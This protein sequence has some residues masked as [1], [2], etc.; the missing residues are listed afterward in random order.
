MEK[1]PGL[2]VQRPPSLALA[3]LLWAYGQQNLRPGARVEEA[4]GL[5][6][7]RR[8]EKGEAGAQSPFRAGQ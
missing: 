2:A 6:P 1:L 3:P 7:L 8:K 5:W 4:A